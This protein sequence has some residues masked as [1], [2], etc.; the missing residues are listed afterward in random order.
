LGNEIHTKEFIMK[1]MY[2]PFKYFFDRKIAI[3]K[4]MLED[5]PPF[6]LPT[7]K[8]LN[9]QLTADTIHAPFKKGR[10]H[11][12][13]ERDRWRDHLAIS[14]GVDLRGLTFHHHGAAW[15]A[16]IFGKKRWIIF[17]DDNEG[18]PGMTRRM[19]LEGADDSWRDILP[20]HE[21][22]R[23]LYPDPWCTGVVREWGM[24]CVQHACED[25]YYASAIVRTS[26]YVLWQKHSIY[27]HKS[28]S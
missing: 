17:R 4:G 19:A 1:H 6:P 10:V 7:R 2:D 15:N 9:D 25:R 5:C 24:D 11:L 23:R 21:W 20:T 8:F 3:P 28:T 18:D 27:L 26:R 13:G 22:I 12:T 14:I 16:V